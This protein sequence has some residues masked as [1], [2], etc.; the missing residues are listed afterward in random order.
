MITY[1]LPV[2]NA[3][4]ALILNTP[5]AATDV[6]L[7]SGLLSI[8]DE[9]GATALK[10][11]A[12]DLLGFRYAANAAGTAN[13]V[14]VE[15]SAA[16]L[17]VNGNY[18][19]TVYAPNVQ[20]FFG[21]GKETGATYQTRTY[22]VGVDATPTAAELAALFVARI[23]ADVKA[24]FTAAVVSSTKV[25]ITESNPGF[26][27]LIVKGPIGSVITDATAWVSPAGTPSQVLNQVGVSTYVTAAG[28]QTYQIIYRKVISHNIVN[29]LQV[30]KPVTALV[31]MNTADA[32]TAATVAKLTSIL[33]GS[34]ATTFPTAAAYLGCPA[35]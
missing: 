6:V 27:A 16:T 18:V 34:Y 25:R 26:G 3:D 35:V 32:N 14:D 31:Y 5:V 10:I 23:N 7:A 11:K 22:E 28:Y 8:K 21:G 4:S 29:G 24:Y 33:D 1:K 13:V 30:T 2:I 19:L 12:T 20:N 17:A 15:L 9:S